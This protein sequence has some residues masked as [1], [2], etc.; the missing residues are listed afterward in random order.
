MITNL[1]AIRVITCGTVADATSRHGVPKQ[2]IILDI[3]F[4][5]KLLIPNGN[6]HYLTTNLTTRLH[7]TTRH[8]TEIESESLDLNRPHTEGF[9]EQSTTIGNHSPE[10]P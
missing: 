8:E 4:F 10:K 5:C 6:N 7:M 1:I 3:I 9:D 2:C